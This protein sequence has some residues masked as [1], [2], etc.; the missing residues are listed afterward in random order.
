MKYIFG[1]LCLFIG[2]SVIAKNCE[3]PQQILVNDC[4]PAVIK[5]CKPC[6]S[7]WEKGWAIT[8]YSGPQSL[9]KIC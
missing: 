5:N 3:Q 6:P 1:F 8:L 4:G 7:W 9:T 2:Q